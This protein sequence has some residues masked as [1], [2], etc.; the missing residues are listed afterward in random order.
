MAMFQYFKRVDGQY[1]GSKLPDPQGAFA[2]EV[3]FVL[4][5]RQNTEVA[6]LQQAGGAKVSTRGT[7]LKM[8]SEKKAE[9]AAE[10]G[11]LATVRYYASRLPEPLKESSVRTVDVTPFTMWAWHVWGSEFAKLFQRNFQ[12]QQFAKIL[13]REIFALYGNF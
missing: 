11:V 9:I 2:Q 8:S 5:L 1:T 3:P 10:H 6:L 4:Y 7:Y 13:T 12:K